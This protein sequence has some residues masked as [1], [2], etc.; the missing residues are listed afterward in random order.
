M[1]IA[2]KVETRRLVRRA[3]AMVIITVTGWQRS[4]RNNHK[5]AVRHTHQHHW[6]VE[7][8]SRPAGWI[9]FSSL[10]IR[11]PV[12]CLV[13]PTITLC[14]CSGQS[15][16]NGRTNTGRMLI[17]KS[18]MADHCGSSFVSRSFFYSGSKRPENAPTFLID[19]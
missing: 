4:A 12:V 5:A 14:S 16:A 3:I 2:Q 9:L 11:S 1:S 6:S 18:V 8:R 19:D 13:P 7:L 17:I 15:F 10:V